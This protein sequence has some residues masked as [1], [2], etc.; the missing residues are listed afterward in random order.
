MAEDPQ[1]IMRHEG[2]FKTFRRKLS[3]RQKIM[4]GECLRIKTF[5]SKHDEIN[6]L[7]IQSE[8]I[9]KYLASIKKGTLTRSA[10]MVSLKRLIG[11]K[12]IN[13]RQIRKF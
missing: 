12:N 8:E 4:G 10:E 3:L 2:L 5:D 9:T 13:I 6:N 7:L 1:K 11:D